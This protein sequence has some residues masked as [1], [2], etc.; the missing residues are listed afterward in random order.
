MPPLSGIPR[1]FII[2]SLSLLFLRAR[3]NANNEHLVQSSPLCR[4][5]TRRFCRAKAIAKRRAV[6]PRATGI[7][8][9]ARRLHRYCCLGPGNVTKRE[10][11]EIVPRMFPRLPARPINHAAPVIAVRFVMPDKSL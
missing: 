5:S 6:A 3:A 9:T 2:S 8:H 10:P 11:V 4:G 7:I 1:A